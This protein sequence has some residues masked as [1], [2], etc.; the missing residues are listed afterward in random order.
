[1]RSLSVAA[2]ALTLTLGSLACNKEQQPPPTQT[3]GSA[4]GSATAA[5]A[6]A[7][8]SE[9][10]P[11]AAVGK[12]APDFTLADLDGK[13]VKLSSFKGKVVVLEWFNP[14]CPFVKRSHGTASLKDAASR[15]TKNGIVWLAINS[16][17]KGKEGNGAAANRAAAEKW[18]M[19]HPIL[20]DE[21][22]AVGKKYGAT[23]TP[24]MFVVD[25]G[26]TLVYKG[27]IDNSPDGEGQSAP[28]G[29]LVGYVDEALAAIAAGKP[30]ST[31]E[32]KAYGCGVKYSN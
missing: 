3:T 7:P 28:D 9:G 26:G 19:T 17:A 30:V 18:G 21:S 6:A 25:A 23:N 12:P 2:L 16:S 31:A 22:G 13:E 5:A 8:V 32:T 27:A 4:L 29:K 14:G 20:L 24:H 11:A 10:A 1:M 15:H